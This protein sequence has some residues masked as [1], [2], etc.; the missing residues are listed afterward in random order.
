MSEL[1]TILFDAYGTVLDVGTYHRDITDYVVK[2]SQALFGTSI[3]TDEFNA[4]WNVEFERA[5]GDVVAYCGEFKNLREL[6]AISTTNVFRRY[7]IDLTVSVVETFNHVYKEMLDAVVTVIPSVT[8]TLS[9][10]CANGH[11]LG[12]VSNGDTEELL[13][14]LN[15]VRDFFEVIV[16]SEELGVYKPHASIFR[17]ALRRIGAEKESAAFV[18]DTVTSDI[19]GARKAGMI[20]I[21][22]NRRRRN[23]KYGIAP[24]FEIRDMTEVLNIVEHNA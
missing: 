5:F 14:H 13:A 7:G 9:T 22:Y 18:G 23:A 1:E 17:E 6:Y 24:D 12:M 11:R 16:T 2:Q 19:L 21:W 15:G 8:E 10:L 4:Y 20:T 3:S